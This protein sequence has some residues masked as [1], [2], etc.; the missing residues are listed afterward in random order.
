MKQEKSCGAIVIDNGRV[1]IVKQNNGFYGFPKGHMD[2]GEREEDT[3]L[4]EVKEETNIDIAVNNKYRYVSSYYIRENILKEVVFFLGR[5]KT[6][7][8][9][10][11]EKEIE[12]VLWMPYDEALKILTYDDSKE[13]LTRLL[14]DLQQNKDEI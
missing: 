2:D 12:E 7:D 8:L 10:A 3:A 14:N 13:L 4:R 1:L 6:M 9:V 11:E 5:P